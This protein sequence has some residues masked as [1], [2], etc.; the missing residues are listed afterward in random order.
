[1][2]LLSFD[3]EEFDLPI[4]QGADI[5]LEESMRVSI[6]GTSIILDILKKHN[7]RATFFCT[8]TFAKNAPDIMTRIIDDGHE[9][10]SHGCNHTH[11]SPYDIENSKREFEQLFPDLEISGYRQPRM[12]EA[13]SK[14]IEKAGYKYD[15]SLHPTFI[16]GRYNHLNMPKVPFRKGNVLEIPCSVSPLF[17]LPVFWL[18]CHNY[19]F[20]LYKALCKWAWRHDGQFIIYF[21]P[22]EFIDISQSPS[23]KIPLMIR[24]NSGTKMAQRFSNLIEMF[25]S[26]GAEFITYKEFVL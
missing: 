25:K 10:A 6:Q 22:W 12:F 23:W 14:Q 17:R 13:D 8:T 1:M 9:V 3:T 4:E 20:G 19:P 5:T 11:P 2:V 26:L 18:A 21:H 7:I 24:H 15:S 16:P